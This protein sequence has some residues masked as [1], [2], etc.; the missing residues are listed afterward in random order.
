MGMNNMATMTKKQAA[1]IIER[2]Q[3]DNLRGFL[4]QVI[5]YGRI[6]YLVNTVNRAGDRR[7]V[8]LAT[9]LDGVNGPR[10]DFFWPSCVPQYT[11]D[12]I[13]EEAREII[14]SQ[15]DSL[16][17][18]AKAI[19]FSFKARSFVVGGGG[20]DMVESLVH[21]LCSKAGMD[22]RDMDSVTRTDMNRTK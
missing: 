12:D 20:M 1:Q 14:G 6:Y 10:L 18:A 13:G 8:T 22:Y 21:G 11:S 7:T 3:I 19:G 15:S 4:A 16:D 5:K 2:I 17:I 9:I